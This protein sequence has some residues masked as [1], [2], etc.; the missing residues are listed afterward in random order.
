MQDLR[1]VIDLGGELIFLMLKGKYVKLSL[2]YYYEPPQGKSCSEMSLRNPPHKLAM[3]HNS[4]IVNE[5]ISSQTPFNLKQPK[6]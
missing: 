2:T 5:L 1:A 4:A 6:N 3:V